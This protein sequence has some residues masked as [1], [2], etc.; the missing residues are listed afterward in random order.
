MTWEHFI[1]CYSWFVCDHFWCGQRFLLLRHARVAHVRNTWFSFTCWWPPLD[2][3]VKRFSGLNT[4]QWNCDQLLVS[5]YNFVFTAKIFAAGTRISSR[6]W[7]KI[8]L[9][10]KLHGEATDPIS[11]KRCRKLMHS[12]P[13]NRQQKQDLVSMMNILEQLSRKKNILSDLDKKIAT[14]QRTKRH[15]EGNFRLRGHTEG[16]RWDIL[17]DK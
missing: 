1:S 14:T 3:V 9:N 11:H 13:K 6:E 15:S 16:S 8:Y 5:Y 17:A 7:P 2:I 12:W 4:L 10:F